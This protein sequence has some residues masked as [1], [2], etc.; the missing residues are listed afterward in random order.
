MNMPSPCSALLAL[1]A[2]AIGLVGAAPT[3]AAAGA[4]PVIYDSDIGDDIDDT[5][6]LV[7]LLKSPELDLR[8]V[9]GDQGKTV[10]RAKLFARVLEVAG[11]TDV[12]VGL[13]VGNKK[14]GGRQS[15][16]VKDYDLDDYPGT[17]HEDGVGAL[18]KT[19][20]ES[21]EPVTVIAVGPTPNLKAALEREPKIA[22][23]ARFVGMHGS[24]YKGYGGKGK[25]DREYNV[26]ACPQGLQAIFAAPWPKTITP[27]DT[28]GLVHLRGKKYAKI[29]DA[30]D[31]VLKALITNYRHWCGKNPER[32][33]KASS[34]L[35]DTVAIYLAAT[36]ADLCKMETL[37]LR[38]TDKGMTVI[39]KENGHTVKAA[40]EWT[41][42]GKYEDWLVER[43]LRPVVKP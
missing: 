4:K 38:V 7:T 29:R 5:W 24:I 23:K 13:G 18:I 30:E 28:C 35:F 27:L 22:T 8:L 15:E 1:A 20:M 33:D 40:V 25:P 43:L 2:L 42:L 14:G 11:R 36:D 41:D 10:Y 3:V 21:D 32:A 6:A 37:P 39:D 26:R 9:V 34:T 16:W 31:P 19:I 12:P 17:V